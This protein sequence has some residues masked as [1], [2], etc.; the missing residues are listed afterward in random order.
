MFGSL[1]GGTGWRF[2]CNELMLAVGDGG[3]LGPDAFD[4]RADFG[5]SGLPSVGFRAALFPA[6]VVLGEGGRGGLGRKRT[7]RHGSRYGS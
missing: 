1:S 7:N 6:T 3:T 5:D 4:F 2:F